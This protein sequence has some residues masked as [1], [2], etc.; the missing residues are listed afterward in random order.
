[1][2]DRARNA[3][4]PVFAW[5]GD[6][7]GA[8]ALAQ[9]VKRLV[10]LQA[11]LAEVSP[12]PGLVALEIDATGVLRVAAPSAAAAAKLRQVEPTLVSAL[13]RRGWAIDRVRVR[14]RPLEGA[15]RPAAGI[16]RGPIPP[17]ALA[18]FG[19]LADEVS[20][21]PLKEALRKLLRHAGGSRAR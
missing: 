9:R 3:A 12:L 8:R 17:Q 10:A 7:A 19:A 15:A 16:P 11:A 2:S 5:L 21:G 6:D 13:R 1:M 18:G 14:P 20:D 4:R